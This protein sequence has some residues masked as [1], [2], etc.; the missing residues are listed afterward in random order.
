V[1]L[2]YGLFPAHRVEVIPNGVD[3]DAWRGHERAEG[4][5]R[6]RLGIGPEAQAVGVVGRFAAQKGIPVFIDAAERL[7]PRFPRLRFVLVGDG[8]MKPEVLERVA[9]SPVASRFVVG[10]PARDVAPYYAMLDVLALPSL[11]EALPYT[12]LEAVSAG[13]PIVASRVGGIAEVITDG[14]SGTLVPPGDPDALADALARRLL[15]PGLARAMAER[16]AERVRLHFRIDRM[17][18]RLESLYLNVAGRAA[19]RPAKAARE[20]VA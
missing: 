17:V 14:V 20:Y 16:A 12:L 4:P 18:D 15:D 5:A 6:A 13:T 8:P 7:A 9:R 1:A 2:G 3:F 19:A 10:P 11:W